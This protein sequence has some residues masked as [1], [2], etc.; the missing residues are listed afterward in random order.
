MYTWLCRPSTLKNVWRTNFTYLTSR[1]ARVPSPTLPHQSSCKSFTLPHQLSCK[2][3]Q[4]YTT[5][6]VVLQEF[7]ILH[8]LTSH[9]ASYLY[10]EEIHNLLYSGETHTH[11]YARGEI[12][13][14]LA[15]GQGE[16]E[17]WYSDLSY[18]L[19]PAVLSWQ[20]VKSFGSQVETQTHTCTCK[21]QLWT[22]FKR[23][24]Q[25]CLVF[26]MYRKA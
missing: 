22:A 12:Y 8:Y 16:T 18:R 2:S 14:Y 19:F 20:P 17:A 6:P 9:P 24:G 23:R 13:D 26:R 4:S 21:W 5:S 1:P 25:I 10:L 3:S 11:F 7:P 15:Q